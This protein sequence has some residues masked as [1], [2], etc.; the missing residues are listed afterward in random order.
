MI[1][2]LQPLPPMTPVQQRIQT[3]FGAILA[4]LVGLTL[5]LVSCRDKTVSLNPDPSMSEKISD[6]I[7]D[8]LDRR[9]GEKVLDVVED[10]EKAGRDIEESVK[11]AVEN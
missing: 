9:P 2:P 3:A 7:D 6:K 8:A 4:L 5:T 10:V 1:S 11:E